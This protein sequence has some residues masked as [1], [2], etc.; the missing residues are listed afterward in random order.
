MDNASFSFILAEVF[1]HE[2]I[3]AT[4]IIKPEK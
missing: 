4:I 3:K 1:V 2:A